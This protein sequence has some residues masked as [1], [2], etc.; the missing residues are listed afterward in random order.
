M[1]EDFKERK[2]WVIERLGD[3][4]VSEKGKKPKSVS[5]ESNK[6]F[7]IPYVNIKAFEKN[8]IDEYTDGIGFL[9]FN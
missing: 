1:K 9:L 3:I 8:E 5:K 4:V 7:Q 2:G 6:E